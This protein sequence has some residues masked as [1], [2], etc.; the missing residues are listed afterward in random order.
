[1]LVL[2]AKS[3]LDEM[4]YKSYSHDWHLIA[5]R[6]NGWLLTAGELLNARLLHAR[7]LLERRTRL[8]LHTGRLLETRAG[9]WFLLE[10]G[11]WLLLEARSRLLLETCSWLLLKRLLTSWHG[12]AGLLKWLLEGFLHWLLLLLL[13]EWLD[14]LL[15]LFSRL[16]LDNLLL[17][18]QHLLV[19]P[20]LALVELVAGLALPHLLVGGLRRDVDGADGLTVRVE[21]SAGVLPLIPRSNGFDQQ[22]NFSRSFVIHHLM[23]VTSLHLQTLACPDNL[24]NISD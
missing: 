12:R 3:C 19:M 15:L 10:A 9:R 4:S 13:W 22:W 18:L 17:L 8:L 21:R 7:R 24:E 23:L 6:W 20:G 1:M 5:G 16:L 14:L 11:C 2:K